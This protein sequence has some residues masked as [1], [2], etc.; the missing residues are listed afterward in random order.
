MDAQQYIESIRVDSS[1]LREAAAAADRSTVVAACPEWNVADL[2]WHI[3]EVQH[4]WGAIVRDRMQDWEGYVEPTRP[5]TDEDVYAFAADAAEQLVAALTDVDPHT[6]V[7][8]WSAQKDV[9]FVIRRM[10]HEVA[11]HRVDA[12]RAAGR[13]HCIDPALASDGIDEFL[14]FHLADE[15][16]GS[17]HLHCTDVDGEWLVAP[18]PDGTK[19][20]TREHAKGDAAI[21]GPAHDLLMVLWRR[22]PLDRVDVIGDRS[23]AERLVAGTDLE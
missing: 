4:F 10:A 22:D 18:G 23:A 19:V 21:R 5:D 16:A 6:P 20:V 1:G 9:A 12:E 8:T 17:V 13:D 7:Y 3:G 11:V 2:V 15:A 14:E